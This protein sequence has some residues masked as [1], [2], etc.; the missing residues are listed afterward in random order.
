MAEIQVPEIVNNYLLFCNYRERAKSTKKIDLSWCNWLFPTT[1]LP[2]G[3]FIKK[4]K[5]MKYLPPHNQNV[6]NYVDLVTGK[7]TLEDAENKS[8][9]PCVYLP[10]NRKE[11]TDILECIFRLHNN[12]KEY[13]GETV[14]KYL[15]GELVD[16]IYE[17]SEF[18][19]ALVM[20]QRY[21]Q[22]G[23]V[24]I[25]F[26]DDGITIPGSFKK[27]GM[28]FEDQ[29]AIMEAVN[30]LSTKSKERGFG[31]S[32]NMTIFTKGMDGKV[33]IVSGRGAVY[34]GKSR[35]KVYKLQ[36]QHRLEGTLISIRIPVPAPK[37]NIYDY[38]N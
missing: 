4:N 12:G 36:D 8:Y 37:V 38:L 10:K 17:H 9:L 24:E 21:D 14:F 26:F 5:S 35:Q 29:Q 22:K 32:S 6:A 3:V 34:V 18:E 19:N 23:F 15:V 33:F 25:C 2:L 1:L 16:N 28:I 20:A 13:G 31:L 11:A 7:I 27:Q 30:G